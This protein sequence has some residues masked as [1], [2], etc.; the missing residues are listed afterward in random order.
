MKYGL[1]S[2]LRTPVKSALFCFL[3]T[4]TI[5][6]LSLGVGMWSVAE[7]ML[8]DADKVFMTA[9]EFTYTGRYDANSYDNNEALVTAY[10]SLKSGGILEEENIIYAEEQKHQKAVVE[11]YSPHKWSMNNLENMF[12]M[13]K[14]QYYMPDYEGYMALVTKTYYSEKFQVGTL[15]FIPVEGVNR[16]L[17]KEETLIVFAES[18]TLSGMA[19]GS[20]KLL[21][22]EE[23]GTEP[24]MVSITE[25]YNEEEFFASEEGKIYQH[26][27]DVYHA[28]NYAQDLITTGKVEAVTAFHMG[29]Y[30][31]MQG[32]FFTENDYEEGNAC[33]IPNK[34]AYALEKEVG[35]TIHLTVYAPVADKGL[36]RCYDEKEDVVYEG[37]FVIRGIYQA[38]DTGTP[39]YLADNGQDFVGRSNNDYVLG[40]V[41]LNNRTAT[42]YCEKL[43][44]R[45]PENVMLTTY[46]E[47][48]D[49][50]VQSIHGLRRTA[51]ILTVTTICITMLIV[52][53]FSYFF[54]NTN[55]ENMKLLLQLGTNEK[56]TFL[57]FITGSGSICLFS[58]LL[59]CGMGYFISDILIQ[60]VFQN[61]VEGSVYDFRFSINGYGVK[62]DSF[63]PTPN[64]E[65]YIFIITGFLIALLLMLW[66]A[67]GIW[68]VIKTFRPGSSRKK[69]G[70][71]ERENAVKRN[72]EQEVKIYHGKSYSVL[73]KIP[74]LSVRYALRNIGRQGI[75]SLIVPILLMILLTFLCVFTCVRNHFK[76]E[77]NHV[78]ENVPV[79][80]QFTDVSG[81]M[82]DNL[83]I[84]Q[85][86]IDELE[87]MG[88]IKEDWK[89]TTY[90]AKFMDI[91]C[92][93]Q[94]P[95][96]ENPLYRYE[97]AAFDLPSGFAWDTMKAQWKSTSDPVQIA[98]TLTEAPCFKY[99]GVPV[100]TWMEGMDA[101]KFLNNEPIGEMQEYGC[102]VPDYYLE[103]YGLALGDLIAL[104]VPYS[105]DFDFTANVV[106]VA[107]S[108]SDKNLQAPIFMTPEAYEA[109]I[110]DAVYIKGPPNTSYIGEKWSSAGAELKNTHQLSELKDYLET[111]YDPVGKAGMHRRWL[112]I[113]DK[114]LYDT[115]DNLTRYIE[116]MNLLYPVIIVLLIAVAFIVSNLLLRNRLREMAMLRSMGCSNV[117]V[118]FSI[119]LE[120]LLLSCAG[121]AV[122][123]TISIIVTDAGEGNVIRNTVAL[124]LCY[125][126]GAF[127][128]IVNGFRKSLM[129]SLK[130]KDE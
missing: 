44:D 70:K 116:Y 111:C 22:I 126:L 130:Q 100:I 45:L 67:I 17:E 89:S 98:E 65:G 74:F 38:Q 36:N 62:S 104:A 69:Q 53:V 18:Y 2:I 87:T 55:K 10:E 95:E 23:N 88:F 13:I 46:N 21:P 7:G 125:Y 90:Y 119:F 59:G 63:V 25:D 32:N 49:A 83:A 118:F 5:V 72:S 16:A 33:L 77:Q 52:G 91:A 56:K 75:K 122:G 68:S 107:G 20:M 26:W 106:C 81:R 29:E 121:V 128:A 41:V 110:V 113:D 123:I 19:M 96:A 92:Y 6:F 34:M 48:Y 84:Y 102:L 24:F 86:S 99:N 117:R 115:I 8:K 124:L 15:V 97:F 27:I 57:F 129:Y 30:T 3:L 31:L 61:I 120:Y 82:F 12:L 101:D 64:L 35:D 50:S 76:Y 79:T 37:D 114:A 78:Y 28:E 40:R 11:N 60:K 94:T 105:D 47:G 103:K 39:I 112:L 127:A 42:A 58:V 109:S 66:C 54:L 4:V 14:V 73:E 108:Y 80:L 43:V 85:E 9:G 51:G 1:K 93:S 71:H